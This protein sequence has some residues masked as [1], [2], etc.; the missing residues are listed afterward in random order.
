[1]HLVHYAHN[2]VNLY[3]NG[4]YITPCCKPSGL[5]VSVEGTGDRNWIG[6]LENTYPNYERYKKSYIV[7]LK[8]GA[9]ILYIN[10]TDDLDEFAKEFKGE[11]LHSSYLPELNDY[12]ASI[13]W[14]RLSETYEGI[15]VTKH[16]SPSMS[17]VPVLAK[18]GWYRTWDCASGCIWKAKSAIREL[19][20]VK[21]GAEAEARI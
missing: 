17:V 10:N 1:M 15:V 19:R 6:F 14:R 8:E 7:L 20:E 2:D 21:H 12:I 4:Q 18:H 9:K 5:W 3:D 11:L 13:D 16:F